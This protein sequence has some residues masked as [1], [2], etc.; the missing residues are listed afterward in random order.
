MWAMPCNLLLQLVKSGHV[1]RRSKD[2]NWL[3]QAIRGMWNLVCFWS[4]CSAYKAYFE[5]VLQ[6]RSRSSWECERSLV[7]L[8]LPY[9]AASCLPK[10]RHCLLQLKDEILQGTS[11]F[12]ESPNM[13]LVFCKLCHARLLS[14]SQGKDTDWCCKDDSQFH[15]NI[16]HSSECSRFAVKYP[17]T[18]LPACV[19]SYSMTSLW[20]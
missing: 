15:K 7:C 3:Y 11:D 8:Y 1:S 19:L 17:L 2:L 13:I 14:A 9:K 20:C 10:W 12:A 6:S 4:L 5:K 16:L 18:C